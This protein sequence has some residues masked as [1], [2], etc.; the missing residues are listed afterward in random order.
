MKNFYEVTYAQ[1]VS[2]LEFGKGVISGAKNAYH[3]GKDFVE[4]VASGAQNVSH[5]L[6]KGAQTVAGH[7]K[8]VADMAA[9]PEKLVGDAVNKAANTIHENTVG[10]V[11]SGWK[12]GAN[13][14]KEGAK[15]IRNTALAGAGIYATTQILK[16]QPH[17]ITEPL[18]GIGKGIVGTAKWVK[19]KFSKAKVVETPHHLHENGEK[20]ITTWV[21]SHPYHTAVGIV[22]GTGAIGGAYALGHSSKGEN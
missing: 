17:L 22:G 11:E 8:K 14:F 6:T 21:K 18:K 9:N 10:R 19:G 20:G 16:H 1:E 7:S 13:D 15:T 3:A 4:G 2:L 12:Q 5:H